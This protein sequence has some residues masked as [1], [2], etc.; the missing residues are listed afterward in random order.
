MLNF[1]A[2]GIYFIFGTKFSWNEG[3]DTCF[4]V[5]C[6]LLG[7]NFDYFGG[8]LV[9]TASYLMVTAR[10]LV[11]TSG[12]CLL[13]VVTVRYQSLLLV[14]TFI[15]NAYFLRFYLFELPEKLF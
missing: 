4:N 14:P 8:Y 15:M 12:Y 5:K 3:I 11:V 1:I 10:Y 6:V 9:V 13:M 7:R 2:L